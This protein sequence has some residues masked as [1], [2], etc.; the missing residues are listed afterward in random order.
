[1]TADMNSL[2]IS[3]DYKAHATNEASDMMQQL[4]EIATSNNVKLSPLELD[5][6]E[7]LRRAER[8]TV[9]EEVAKICDEP[10]L[11]KSILERYE[12]PCQALVVWQPPKKVEE[13]IAMPSECKTKEENS[14]IEDCEIDELDNNSEPTIQFDS[15]D[16]DM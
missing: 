14:E 9:C 4:E 3:S 1:M 10:I 11:P 2:H 7:K 6:Q 8:I 16:L 15:M 12:R 5:I 13:L